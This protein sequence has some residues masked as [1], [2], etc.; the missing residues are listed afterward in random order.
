M[1]VRDEIGQCLLVLPVVSMQ[2]GFVETYAYLAVKSAM[3]MILMI[4]IDADHAVH[5]HK[6]VRCI[7]TVPAL[8]VRPTDSLGDLSALPSAPLAGE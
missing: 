5:M 7:G 6:T 3:P 1:T 4:S 8:F 2:D